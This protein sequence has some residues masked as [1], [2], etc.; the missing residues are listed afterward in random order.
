MLT[1]APRFKNSKLK[2]K[3]TKP[4]TF[5]SDRQKIEAATTYLML[6][7]NG[8]LTA[9]T[10]GI[11]VE[12]LYLWMKSDWWNELVQSIRREEKLQLS[13]RLKKIVESS[14]SVVEDRLEK[15]DFIYDQKQQCLVRKP[16]PMKDAAKVAAEAS[17][18][19][20]SLD[21]GEAATTHNDAIEEKL[22]KLAKAF[23]D[24]SR[25]ITNNQSVEDVKYLETPQ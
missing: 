4:K 18:L 13:A 5:Y 23:T 7:G 8:S 21:L 22:T 24:L 15:G 9:K 1:D 19:R 10:L 16:V 25:G 20:V 2:G 3:H 14:W 17:H 12:T 11:N 6:G